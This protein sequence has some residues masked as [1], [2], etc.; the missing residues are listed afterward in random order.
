M[1]AIAKTEREQVRDR[2]NTPRTRKHAEMG[3]DRRGGSDEWGGSETGRWQAIQ[4]C[5]LV[6]VSKSLKPRFSRL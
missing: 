6:A 3:R 2:E 4:L 1:G 5:L